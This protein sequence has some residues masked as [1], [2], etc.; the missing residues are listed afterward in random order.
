MNPEF[1]NLVQSTYRKAEV[2]DFSAG[3]TVNVSVLIREGEK[4]RIQQFQGTVM[5]RKNRNS[6][7][8]TFTLR[9]VARGIAVE[10]IFPINSPFVEK[11]ELIRQGKVRRARLYYLRGRKGRSARIKEKQTFTKNR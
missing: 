4:E 9:K 5:Q 2:P 3:D 7:G 10:R 11:I 1:I 8:E 6:H